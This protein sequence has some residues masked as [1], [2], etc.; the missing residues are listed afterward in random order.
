LITI[1]VRNTKDF[2]ALARRLQ[3]ASRELRSE[4]YKAINRATRPLKEDVR[5]AAYWRLPKKGGLNK[6]ISTSK[7]VTK[8]RMSGNNAGVRIVG[9]S[10]YDIGSINR[11][12]VRHLTFGHLPWSDQAV[13]PGFWTEPLMKGAPAV[14]KEIDEAMKRI[15]R[16]VEKG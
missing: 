3:S 16:D 8:R 1:R 12:R 2:T 10:G 15:A 14:R 7:I 6:R 13:K 4:L 11:G 5:G 9:S